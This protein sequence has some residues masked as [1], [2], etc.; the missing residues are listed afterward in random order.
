MNK[1]VEMGKGRT[2]KNYKKDVLLN[3]IEALLPPSTEAWTECARRYQVASG[4]P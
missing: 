3:V 1:K 4:Q 2:T